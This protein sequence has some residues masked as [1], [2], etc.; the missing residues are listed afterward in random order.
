M[1]KP[2]HENCIHIKLIDSSNCCDRKSACEC[3]DVSCGQQQ[4]LCEN[5]H[6]VYVLLF[7]TLSIMEGGECTI[8]ALI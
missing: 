4:L 2:P 8:N 7:Y 3:L 6:C 1:C 5:A